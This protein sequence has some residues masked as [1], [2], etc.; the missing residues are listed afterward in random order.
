MKSTT[1]I[2]TTLWL[3]RLAVCDSNAASTAPKALVTVHPEQPGA[4]IPAD[5]L[6]FSYEKSSLTESHFRANNTEMLNLLK[7]LGSGVLRFGGN[8]VE[9]TYWSRSETPPPSKTKTTSTKKIQTIGP[10]ALDNLYAFAKQSGWRVLHGLNLGANDPAM[11]ADEAAYALKVGGPMVL[12]FEVGNEPDF[13]PRHE[14]RA[15]NY[16]YAE[17]RTEAQA[18]QRAILAK[19]PNALLAGPAT[20]KFCDWLPGFLTDF[21]GTIALATSHYYSLSS[22]SKDPRSANFATITNLL[23][24]ATR[25]SGMPMIE[26]HQKASRAANIPFRLA[27]CNTVSGGGTEGVSDVFASTLWGIDFLFD[28]AERGVAGINFHGSF[29]DRGYTAFC[30]NNN[31]YHAHPLYYSMLLFHQAA[32]GR[33]VPV[34]CQSTANV[35]AHAV[36]GEDHKLRVV[37]V[38]KDLSQPV[39]VSVVSGS[40][41]VKA[42]VIRLTAPAITAKEGI[43]LAGSAVRENGTWIPQS[44][45]PVSCVNGVFE[46]S[47]PAASAAM[48]TIE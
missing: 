31:H 26:D 32:K 9:L 38:N 43:T 39:V 28:V 11:A 35:T 27:E 34:E 46:V 1:L 45:E 42:E 12:A 13:Y 24:P 48:L 8:Q 15:T 29:K 33:V 23:N 22:K 20:T 21:K 36:L 17:Y 10:V 5:F 25:K 41:R 4:T 37:L 14:L 30:F 44:S 3:T 19:S 47:L 40:P 16:G 6:G 18:E 2:L 7:N